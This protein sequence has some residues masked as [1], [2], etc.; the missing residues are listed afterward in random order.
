M[1]LIII[2]GSVIIIVYC[3]LP[4]NVELHVNAE[5]LKIMHTFN[6]FLERVGYH[7]SSLLIT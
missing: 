7:F 5:D 1:C 6:A 2:S 3:S 4:N